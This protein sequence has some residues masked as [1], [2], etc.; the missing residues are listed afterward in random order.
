MANISVN[1][2]EL[3]QLLAATPATHTLMLVGNHGIGKSETLTEFFKERDMQVVALF[4]G[5]M[6]DP[7]DLI[8]LP[9]KDGYDGLVILTDGYAPEPILPEGFKTGLLWVCENQECF[10]QHKSW[11]EKTGRACVMQIG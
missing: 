7:G 9:C 3:K 2:T 11:M 10:D 5:Q 4:L 8:G 1:I 6:A